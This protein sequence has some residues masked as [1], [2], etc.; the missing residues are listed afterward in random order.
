MN[1][2]NNDYIYSITQANCVI[3]ALDNEYKNKIP[4][5]VVNFFNNNS[6]YSLLNEE[7]E[8]GKM[9]FENF[10]DDTLKFLKVIDYYINK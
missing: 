8:N 5:N 6:D 1:N 4:Q 3:N 10:T 2:L 9:T 7:F